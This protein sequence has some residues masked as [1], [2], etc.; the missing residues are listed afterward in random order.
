MMLCVISQ[1]TFVLH[2]HAASQPCLVSCMT[3]ANV[4]A[5]S[6]SRK[7]VLFISMCMGRL[8]MLKDSERIITSKLYNNK[9]TINVVGCADS[10]YYRY[11]SKYKKL[12]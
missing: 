5:K 6:F 1:Y 9:N 4:V 10:V 3:D 11:K 7:V 12:V 2:D 8:Y